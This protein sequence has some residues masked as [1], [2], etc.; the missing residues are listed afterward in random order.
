[1]PG[2]VLAPD[3]DTAHRVPARLVQSETL[4][5]RQVAR[6]SPSL[7]V[8]VPPGLHP[9]WSSSLPGPISFG[10]RL[11]PSLFLPVPHPLSI[12]QNPIGAAA[13]T[14]SEHKGREA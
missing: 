9:S 12:L 14:P 5:T 4:G 6:A 11:P 1:M 2:P 8:P 7:P 13:R 3:G 10:P